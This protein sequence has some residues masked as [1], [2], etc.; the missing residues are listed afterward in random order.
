MTPGAHSRIKGLDK[1]KTGNNLRD[2]MTDL[3]LI[4]TMLGEASTTEIAKRKDAQGLADNRKAAKEG[5]VV[6]GNARKELEEKSGKP[7]VSRQN[8]LSSPDDLLKEINPPVP[9]TQRG[10]IG[11]KKLKNKKK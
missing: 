7:V 9:A 4:F 3:E 5:G 1:V 8:Y 10:K 6:A 2:H 11:E